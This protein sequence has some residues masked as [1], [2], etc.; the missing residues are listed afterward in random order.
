VTASSKEKCSA[1]PPRPVSSW[2]CTVSGFTQGQP[3][4]LGCFDEIAQHVRRSQFFGTERPQT[5]QGLGLQRAGLAHMPLHHVASRLFLCLA[6]FGIQMAVPGAGPLDPAE[7]AG[8]LVE[9][10]L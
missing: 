9:L 1:P 4:Q 5:F 2:R 6:G 3:F 7:G 8:P 10:T